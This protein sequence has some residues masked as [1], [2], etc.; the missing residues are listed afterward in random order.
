MMPVLLIILIPLG[1]LVIYAIVFDLKQRRTA[2]PPGVTT[3]ARGADG[4]CGRGRPWRQWP[5]RQRRR[6]RDWPRR[7]RRG[8]PRPLMLLRHSPGTGVVI[9]S[10]FWIGA[11][12]WKHRP[13][14]SAG[15]HCCG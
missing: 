9:W 12:S 8:W 4:S 11:G 2:A 14:M 15:V 13:S 7:P 10:A 6:R 1:A 5:R 3:S